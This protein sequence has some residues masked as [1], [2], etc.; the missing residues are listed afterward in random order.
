[1]LRSFIKLY[2]ARNKKLGNLIKTLCIKSNQSNFTRKARFH[3]PETLH[4][5]RYIE[6]I[7]KNIFKEKMND[8]YII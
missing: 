2:N 7:S 4:F 6:N 8:M 1:M 3:K 5:R